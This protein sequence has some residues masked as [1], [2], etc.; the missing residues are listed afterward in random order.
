MFVCSVLRCAFLN[1]VD[2]LSFANSYAILCRGLMDLSTEPSAFLEHINKPSI[3]LGRDTAL[4]NWPAVEW[5]G[6]CTSGD[7]FRGK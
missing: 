1:F 5:P 2:E 3:Y 4:E 6:K 7:K